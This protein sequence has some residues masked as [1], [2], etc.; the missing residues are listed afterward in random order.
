MATVGLGEGTLDALVCIGHFNSLKL[1]HHGKVCTIT[2]QTPKLNTDLAICSY[3]VKESFLIGHT[4][5]LLVMW[6]VMG[7]QR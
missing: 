3:G 5:F 1:F 7:H 6:M 2:F 4:V